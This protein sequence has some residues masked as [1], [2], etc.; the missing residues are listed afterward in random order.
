MAVSAKNRTTKAKETLIKRE[1]Q[2][3]ICLTTIAPFTVLGLVMSLNGPSHH[4]TAFLCLRRQ[5][6]TVM[7]L[8]HSGE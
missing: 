6:L 8:S 2:T 1:G 5:I 3:Q 7:A 4:L